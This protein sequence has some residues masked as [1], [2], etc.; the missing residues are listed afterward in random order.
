MPKILIATKNP[1]KAREYRKI[2]EPK[3]FEVTTLLDLDADQVP[4][5]DENG[6]SFAENALIKE[7]YACDGFS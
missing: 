5:I 4:A 2:F 7:C 1:G 6:S 3:G